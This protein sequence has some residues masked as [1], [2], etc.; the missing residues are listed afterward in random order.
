MPLPT[1]KP[2]KASEPVLADPVDDKLRNPF[3]RAVLQLDW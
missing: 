1:G 2:V 3:Q